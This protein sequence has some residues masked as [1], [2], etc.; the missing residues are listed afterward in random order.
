M[1]GR[2]HAAI[3][4]ALTVL[5]GACVEP[6]APAPTPDPVGLHLHRLNGAEYAN[7]LAAVLGVESDIAA[8][9]PDDA[10]SLGFDNVASALTTSPLLLEFYAQATDRALALA[11][12]PG[13]PLRAELDSCVQQRDEPSCASA[14]IERLARLAWRRPVSEAERERLLAVYDEARTLELDVV[15]G[16]DAALQAVLLSPHFLFR[17]E[18]SAPAGA[19]EPV[20]AHE[21]AARLSYFLWSGP[22]DLELLDAADTGALLEPD[23]LADQARRML[24]DPRAAALADN[25]AA[26]WLA[27]RYLDDVFKDTAR[28]PDFTPQLRAS[29]AEEPRRLFLDLLERDRDLRELLTADHAFLDTRLATF[30]GLDQPEPGFRRVALGDAPRRGVLTQ[31]GLMAVLAYPFTTSPARRGSF[32]LS[33]FLCMPL[34][35]PPPGVDIPID[36]DAQGKREQLEAHRANPACASCHASMDP[37]GLAFEGYDAIGKHRTLDAGVAIDTS[38]SLP[39]GVAFADPIELAAAIADDPAFVACAV[40]QTMTYALGRGLA[41]SERAEIDELAV[42]L[43]LRGYGLRELFVLVATSESFRMRVQ[44]PEP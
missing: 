16:I 35:A 6:S 37:I 44:E 5:V 24:A 2:P 17:I 21:L 29:M 26:Q 14:L 12:A 28:H 34:A 42:E 25:F 36:L 33:N 3:F 10:P 41:A 18:G 15:E 39:S 32:V 31:A 23:V 9:L 7:S 11:L 13:G 4:A 1:S 20:T 8:Q 22:P 43:E 40:Q 38:G 30:Y 27:Y 19:R